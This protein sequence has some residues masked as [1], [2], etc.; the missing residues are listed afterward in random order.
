MYVFIPIWP[1]TVSTVAYMACHS[2][3]PSERAAMARLVAPQPP[4][5][6]G[7]T[8]TTLP[9]TSHPRAV[10]VVGYMLARHWIAA[11]TTGATWP[12]N[13]TVRRLNSTAASNLGV[14]NTSVSYDNVSYTAWPPGSPSGAAGQGIVSWIRI[15]NITSSTN[16]STGSTNISN[17][18]NSDS[19]R[20]GLLTAISL[21]EEASPLAQM[22]YIC[23]RAKPTLE[24]GRAI[25]VGLT[26]YLALYDALQNS[27]ARDR[28]TA[29][30]GELASVDPN[31]VDASGGSNSAV[32]AALLRLMSQS[33]GGAS[34][35]V[36]GNC[37]A[38]YGGW[39]AP[40]LAAPDQIKNR[41][42]IAWNQRRFASHASGRAAAACAAAGSGLLQPV[43]GSTELHAAAA[44]MLPA[45]TAAGVTEVWLGLTL[46]GDRW[47]WDDPRP[48][49]TPASATLAAML[50]TQAYRHVQYW[51]SELRRGGLCRAMK[52]CR[53][54]A[55]GQD[56]NPDTKLLSELNGIVQITNLQDSLLLRMTPGVVFPAALQTAFTSAVSA[57]LRRTADGAATVATLRV[58][59]LLSIRSHTSSSSSARS[60]ASGIAGPGQVLLYLKATALFP[61]PWLNSANLEDAIAS[62][63]VA[64]VLPNNTVARLGPTTTSSRTVPKSYFNK[65]DSAPPQ[66]TLYGEP[67]LTLDV[68]SSGYEDDGASCVDG[69]EGPLPASAVV[70]FG[71][72]ISTAQATPPGVPTLIFYG[73]ADA[74]GNAARPV[75]RQIVV[76]DPCQ[77]S[78]E[79]T[80]ADSGECSVG[81]AE[82]ACDSLDL[83]FMVHR[84]Q[85]PES[86]IQ[87]IPCAGFR[88]FLKAKA[89]YV[90]G[91]RDQPKP[92][93][94]EHQQNVSQVTRSAAVV[95]RTP[96]VITLLDPPSTY[97]PGVDYMSKT[98]TNTI[99]GR[100]TF[101]LANTPFTDPGATAIDDVDGDVSASVARSYPAEG[102]LDT[103]IPRAQSD[104]YLITYIATDSAGNRAV[105][106]RRVYVICADG[107]RVCG[108]NETEDGL[109][110]CST[111]GICGVSGGGGGGGSS[112]GGSSTTAAGTNTPPQITLLGEPVV[113]LVEGQ[114][115]SYAPC[116]RQS[117]LRDICDPGVV[118][119]DAED[120]NLGPLVRLCGGG[121]SSGVGLAS[122]G[123]D[124]AAAGTYVINYTVTDS[125]GAAAWVARTLLICPS[126]E[127]VCTAGGG[128]SCSFAGVGKALEPPLEF[129]VIPEWQ[130]RT[131]LGRTSPDRCMYVRPPI[132]SLQEILFVVFDKWAKVPRAT[133][134]RQ[135]TIISPCAAGRYYCEG[136]KTCSDVPCDTRNIIPSSVAAATA[137]AAT[138]LGPV[139]F[140]VD[141]AAAASSTL[142]AAALNATTLVNATVM[143]SVLNGTSGPLYGQDHQVYVPYGRPA[144]YSF[145]PCESIS[146][147]TSCGAV[148][149]DATD[150][151]LSRSITV[152]PICTAVTAPPAP[153]APDA[154]SSADGTEAADASA[155]ND[156]VTAVQQQSSAC[157]LCSA[158]FLTAG[159]CAPGIYTLRYTVTDSD[160]WSASMT[161]VVIVE[162]RASLSLSLNFTASL[163][164]LPF[165]PPPAPPL[166]PP[167]PPSPPS[168]P[169]PTQVP[170]P[171]PAPAPPAAP[172]PSPPPD[173]MDGGDINITA[174]A[175]NAAAMFVRQLR[176]DPQ[177][178]AQL[179]A[180]YSS[181]FGVEPETVRSV[182]VTAAE[183]NLAAAAIVEDHAGSG[184]SDVSVDYGIRRLL[185]P[186]REDA[187]PYML[188]DGGS[189]VVAATASYPMV[190][191]SGFTA[192]LSVG[193]LTASCATPDLDPTN[194]MLAALAGATAAIVDLH[195]TMLEATLA[196]K[197]TFMQMED[198]YDQYDSAV[199]QAYE[200]AHSLATTALTNA[201]ATAQEIL[202][203][204]DM[205]LAVQAA[206]DDALSAISTLT[207]AALAAA[208][209]ATQIAA[210][211]TAVVLSSLEA[212]GYDTTSDDWKQMENCMALRGV[213]QVHRRLFDIVAR[214]RVLRTVTTNTRTGSFGGYEVTNANLLRTVFIDDAASASAVPPRVLGTGGSAIVAGVF[215]HQRRI[216]ADVLRERY[217]TCT[218]PDD[219][220]GGPFPGALAV[221]CTPYYSLTYGGPAV[222]GNKAETVTEGI[223]VDAVFNRASDLYDA[224]L[225]SRPEDYYNTSSQAGFLNRNGVPYGFHPSP[226]PLAGLGGG[227]FPVL[228]DTA[229]TA[230]RLQH[231]LAALRQ[232]GYLNAHLTESMTAQV[233]SYNSDLR[234]FGYWRAVFRW[235]SQGLVEAS[236]SVT[237]LPAVTW[238]LSNKDGGIRFVIPDLLLVLLAAWYFASTVYD[239][240][241]SVQEDRLRAR[242]L[243]RL[244][245]MHARRGMSMTAAVAATAAAGG[246]AAALA[247]R[248]KSSLFVPSTGTNSMRRQDQAVPE[249]VLG[250]GSDPRV[251][252]DGPQPTAGS[253][254]L[255]PLSG[256]GAAAAG[257]ALPTDRQGDRTPSS[258]GREDE[259]G[260][261]GEADEDLELRDGEMCMEAEA[262]LEAAV[263]AELEAAVEAELEAAVEAELE[264]ELEQ[265]L[266]EEEGDGEGTASGS[267]NGTGDGLISRGPY[268]IGEATEYDMRYCGENGAK[269]WREL[270]PLRP[271]CKATEQSCASNIIDDLYRNN[272]SY[273]GLYGREGS[274]G[275]D[276]AAKA[277]PA[278]TA[279]GYF[280]RVHMNTGGRVGV[281]G[282][283]GPNQYARSR[284]LPGSR[285]TSYSQKSFNSKLSFGGA[286]L[287]RNSSKVV[288]RGLAVG[289]DKSIMM[290]SNPSYS[291]QD[292][293]KRPRGPQLTMP[294]G[295]PSRV[296]EDPKAAAVRLMGQEQEVV[297]IRSKKGVKAVRKYRARMT[298]FWAAYELMV[299]GF[300]AACLAILFIYSLQLSRDGP[301]RLRYDVYDSLSGAPAHIFMLRRLT[302]GRDNAT[303]PAPGDPLRWTL[304][305]DTSGLEGVAIL[306]D[307]VLHMRD[308]WMLY[309]FFQ[310]LVLVLLIMRLVHRL[311]FQPRLSI[312]SGT[313]ARMV[314]DLAGFVL[315]L[316]IILVMFAMM[317]V[318]LW[319][320]TIEQLSRAADGVVWTIT[321]FITALD[322]SKALDVVHA[323]H[324][325]N[326]QANGA[327]MF[328]SWVVTIC[329]PLFFIFTLQHFVMALLAWPFS[330][331]KRIFS[332]APKNKSIMKTRRKSGGHSHTSTMDSLLA[333]AS[334]LRH[335]LA[336][337]LAAARRPD[338]GCRT[339]EVAVD[340]DWL[341]AGELEQ[342]LAQLL[343]RRGRRVPQLRDNDAGKVVHAGQ[344]QRDTL[345]HGSAASKQP[346]R[347]SSRG[348]VMPEPGPHVEVELECALWRVGGSDGPEVVVDEASGRGGDGR[349]SRRGCS[350]PALAWPG[351]AEASTS[352]SLEAAVAAVAMN[353]VQ[354]MGQLR[355]SVVR[356]SHS[357]METVGNNRPASITASATNGRNGD[358][359]NGG[360]QFDANNTGNSNSRIAVP[361]PSLAAPALEGNNQACTASAPAAVAAVV[362]GLAATA[363]AMH[364]GPS[365]A[366]TSRK[367]LR[368]GSRVKFDSSVNADPEICVASATSPF[369]ST[370]AQAN[371]A[372]TATTTAAGGT[373]L[374]R[375]P[376]GSWDSRLHQ[377]LSELNRELTMVQGNATSADGATGM[378]TS[379]AA[380]A[381][382]PAVSM[383]RTGSTGIRSGPSLL[384]ASEQPPASLSTPPPMPKTPL[385]LQAQSQSQRQEQQRLFAN[386]EGILESTPRTQELRERLVAARVVSGVE[387]YASSGGA[388]GSIGHGGAAEPLRSKSWIELIRG[389]RNSGGSGDGAK[390]GT[391]RSGLEPQTLILGGYFSATEMQ[392]QRTFKYPCYYRGY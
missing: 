40:G 155:T 183:M 304:P 377:L 342:L 322:S 358:N 356:P 12:A 111:A 268:G 252:G 93:Q 60:S 110:A 251:A 113:A 172:L 102:A 199:L 119:T 151:D 245:K 81:N 242:A 291:F 300:M 25:E 336:V 308:M 192:V 82:W 359:G 240:V 162:E 48:P 128:L 30:G 7:C 69:T 302:A 99:R 258:G 351:N 288:S 188:S 311:S 88:G 159:A 382:A 315:V 380:P 325:P 381:P 21:W 360:D 126:S 54:S 202:T 33:V 26:Q 85:N 330:E 205:T 383:V 15:R 107:E 218:P 62:P 150:G 216:P 247:G 278:G 18:R 286:S 230:T 39:D 312:I 276:P 165:P 225:E 370:F 158:E 71:L 378:A 170:T 274:L 243:K 338:V 167:S 4:A 118:A 105:A 75:V 166:P 175:Y 306:Y 87:M 163:P 305:E 178:Q 31:F 345:T 83:S 174:M 122:C 254:S 227:G 318:V 212:Y 194:I 97:R 19:N 66:L 257:A 38:M 94:G 41:H 320:D 57:E 63:V 59:V 156:D 184:G 283:D 213:R 189:G 96:P 262:E 231:V 131:V 103:R 214:R 374:R 187:M 135:I 53:T 56:G 143:A 256:V 290:T 335:K 232:G 154:D 137:A 207:E 341:S 84:I 169:A 270:Q 132:G 64:A 67:E 79:A 77:E 390:A 241:V 272:S 34:F 267:G 285:T 14:S 106:F 130:P 313:L 353:L 263:E 153:P 146:S 375:Q 36:A 235:G 386:L 326:N 234:I 114:F 127:V 371:T 61:A 350:S 221:E 149:A 147:I 70:T 28:C 329:G 176:M 250:S 316:V 91:W 355:N 3:L 95:D 373:G 90:V 47:V 367:N 179:V 164:A 204:L 324:D 344:V 109:A 391:P 51:C 361:T 173:A 144:P 29:I 198:K 319:G 389:I 10:L 203:L 58:S 68:L 129:F 11:T 348:S 261:Q 141:G 17:V 23:V 287:S 376:E 49:T 191:Q 321:Y 298:P 124:T 139:L 180:E 211:T 55:G 161:R 44:A 293:G 73:C 277:R 16:I 24:L 337:S 349:G 296:P 334:Q 22:P 228:L 108:A 115:R 72:P 45:A 190:M 233:V 339:L 266:Q 295:M 384:K 145:L 259:G 200:E 46:A 50:L 125:G 237:G 307:K 303:L 42:V 331:L 140:L 86:R 208:T 379:V 343:L 76:Y 352:L 282:G 138:A 223:G 182:N 185:L 168:P 368:T 226:I 13:A 92:K 80:C 101:L 186:Y 385:Q 357:S 2:P 195:D 8:C 362:Q 246:T 327:Y 78:G 123:I 292:D 120:G 133:A 206:N 317:L 219:D 89:E 264:A 1:C 35:W 201:S 238:T 253:L 364:A 346:Q 301:Q 6:G 222:D 314:P 220:G 20:A 354:R 100:I 98:G 347:T 255:S 142:T 197:T 117:G 196:S 244:L 372:A 9:L 248:S 136:D 333:K 148:A 181:V 289:Y 369:T 157:A 265:E 217:D 309:N 210:L 260:Q 239:I 37:T 215:L 193:N 269:E 284:L 280:S 388:R 104:P 366:S 27:A 271:G 363:S 52:R 365:A 236:F 273:R 65:T 121:V 224:D 209:G 134:A 177:L 74:A 281:R 392:L 323:I 279:S 275:N 152:V 387:I 332:S 116:T 310:G 249:P 43:S 294:L 32:L 5:I 340:D 299:C 229:L 171:L 112:G 160:S 297:A 328:M